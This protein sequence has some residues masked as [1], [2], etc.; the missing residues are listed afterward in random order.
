VGEGKA[1]GDKVL[2]GFGGVS[3]DDL[4]DSGLHL[5][6]DGGVSGGNSVLPG[7]ARYDDLGDLLAVV[8][9]LVG[10]VEVNYKVSRVCGSGLGEGP[11]DNPGGRWTSDSRELW[12]GRGWWKGMFVEVVCV[13]G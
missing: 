3:V 13:P 10:E 7:Y 12:G 1:S 6:D 8:D 5:G 11:A 4:E 9:G 2:L